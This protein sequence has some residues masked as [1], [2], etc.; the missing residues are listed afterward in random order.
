MVL[1]AMHMALC[2]IVQNRKI[3]NTWLNQLRSTF[4]QGRITHFLNL[5]LHLHLWTSPSYTIQYQ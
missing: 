4:P 5:T 1:L 3:P 2:T